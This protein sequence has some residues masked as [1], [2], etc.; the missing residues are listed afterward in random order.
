MPVALR[1]Q[2]VRRQRR[3][4]ATALSLAIVVVCSAISGADT[5]PDDEASVAIATSSE[6]AVYRGGKPLAAAKITESTWPNRTVIT[7]DRRFYARLSETAGGVELV[8]ISDRDG[9]IVRRGCAQCTSIAAIGDHHVMTTVSIPG[10][11]SF[12]TVTAFLVFDVSTSEP[13]GRL[14][15]TPDHVRRPQYRAGFQTSLMFIG[16]SGDSVFALGSDGASTISRIY[17]INEYGQ[18]HD[19]GLRRYFGFRD[20]SDVGWG[21]VDTEATPVLT[22][23]RPGVGIAIASTYERA[24]FGGDRL[25]CSRHTT[26][27]ILAAPEAIISVAVDDALADV[28]DLAGRGT[29]VT[30]LWQSVD[31]ILHAVVRVTDCSDNPAQAPTYFEMAYDNTT[32]SYVT[33]LT[34]PMELDGADS[35]TLGLGYF[36]GEDTFQV[37][38]PMLA[39]PVAGAIDIIGTHPRLFGGPAPYTKPLGIGSTEASTRTKLVAVRPIGNDRA[40]DPAY[41]VTATSS[42]ACKDSRRRLTK[43]A[44]ECDSP[45]EH[46]RYC[47]YSDTEGEVYCLRSFADR[48]VVKLRVNGNLRPPGSVSDLV[49]RIPIAIR[50]RDGRY[51]M[52]EENP[53]DNLTFSGTYACDNGTVVVDSE[54]S[55]PTSF[56]SDGTL[57]FADV[58]ARNGDMSLV[59]VSE[60]YL[61]ATT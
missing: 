45:E 56:R 54:P 46:F 23:E 13:P 4:I 49:S 41:T 27:D 3:A 25:G 19:W 1:P 33:E 10:N 26:I 14:I 8:T 32:L 42:G 31:G 43:I 39:Q 18:I 60:F 30:R 51:C 34:R 24:P 9:A 37:S 17:E 44:V 11:E 29:V 55:G 47:W 21:L 20:D 5:V 36:H 6:L 7:N 53:P 2:P 35:V 28:V 57:F 59:Q 16:S 15:P 40:L 48:D 52:A 61:L 50:L 38:S 22:S 58:R 12:R